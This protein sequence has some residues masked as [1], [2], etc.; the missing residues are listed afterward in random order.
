MLIPPHT[1]LVR[2]LSLAAQAGIPTLAVLEFSCDPFTHA[3][4]ARQSHIPGPVIPGRVRGDSSAGPEATIHISTPGRPGGFADSLGLP[5]GR[6]RPT[7]PRKR[8]DW[9]SR[10]KITY[11][12]VVV[13]RLGL[14]VVRHLGY[15]LGANTKVRGSG[16]RISILRLRFARRGE[17][18]RTKSIRFADRSILFCRT[19]MGKRMAGAG[20]L[21]WIG[22][23]WIEFLISY[24]YEA[25]APP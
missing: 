8:C 10:R 9:H 21:C 13:R 5:T 12:K 4:C 23:D 17:K 20:Q 16:C 22:L 15:L 25:P 7:H 19:R 18:K 24:L 1:A 2:R 6:Q 11:I 14:D 3:T